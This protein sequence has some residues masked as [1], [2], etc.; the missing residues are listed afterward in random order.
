[1]NVHYTVSITQPAQHLLDVAIHVGDVQGDHLDFVLPTW[2]PGSY[3]I[4]EYARHVQNV[5][6]EAGDQPTVWQKIDKQTWR[7]ATNSAE[8]V[9]LRYRVYGNELTVRTN[10]VDDMHAHVIP[11][12]TFMYVAGTTEQPLHVTVRELPLDWN[13]AT[14]L[15][16]V[17]VSTLQPSNVPIFTADNY[18]HL[19]DS[20]FEI[21]VHRVLPFDVDGKPHQIVVWGHGNENNAR[22]VAD[23]QKIVE[24][25]RDFWGELPYEHY[26]FFVLLGGKNAGGGLEHRNSTSLLLPRFTFKPDRSYERYLTLVSHEFFHVWNVKRL[27]AQ[28]LGPFDYTQE[29]YTTLLWAMEGIT[30]YYTDLL[31][32][33]AGL[34]TRE[35]YLERLADDIVTLQTTPGRQVQGLEC[36]SFDAWIKLYRPDENSANTSVSYYLKGAVV[37]ALL[38]LE[39]RRRAA[40]KHSLD[41]VMHHLYQAYPLDGPGVA[42]RYGYVEAINEVTGQDLSDFFD[43]YIAGTDELPYEEVLGAAGLALRWSSKDATNGEPKPTLGV[44]LKQAGGQLLVA[45]VLSDGPAYSAGL[46]ADDEIVA[47]NG[48]RVADEAALRERLHDQRAGETVTL[49]VFRRE[50]QRTIAVVLTPAPHDKL[51]IEPVVEPTTEQQRIGA[52]WLGH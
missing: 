10:H 49:T 22:L 31:L 13:I 18:D 12:A 23:T 50:A 26:T 43:R 51:V 29:T 38:D 30:E 11:A 15:D 8:H 45:S 39:I 21:G 20:P 1:M 16:Q 2:T 19:I 17:D 5:V 24:T 34:L 27:R 36:A 44:R 42:D 37:A 25:A 46:H 41:D 40:G 14:G 3:L 33:R 6:A 32:L 47:I 28:G 9:V 52:G 4:R 35:R 48:Y 7:V